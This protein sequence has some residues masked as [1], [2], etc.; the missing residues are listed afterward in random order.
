M[1]LGL[2]TIEVNEGEVLQPVIENSAPAMNK[3]PD[4]ER[5]RIQS[6]GVSAEP[7]WLTSTQPVKQINFSAACLHWADQLLV[8]FRKLQS[9]VTISRV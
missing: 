5:L 4:N 8:G 9:C 2:T 3:A 1:T 7:A 6:P